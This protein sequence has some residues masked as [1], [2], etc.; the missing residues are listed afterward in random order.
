MNLSVIVQWDGVDDSLPVNY[1]V[2]WTSDERSSNSMQ[3]HTLMNKTSY[4]IIGL[5]ID[6][7]Y[8]ITVYAANKGCTGPEYRSSILFP[9]GMFHFHYNSNPPI[10]VINFIA[11]NK[12][13]FNMLYSG[14]LLI[15]IFCLLNNYYPEHDDMYRYTLYDIK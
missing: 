15:T 10:N 12:L 2:K 1:T 8:T 7:V 5:T 4:T 9:T 11:C 14:A 13:K 6:T 3:S